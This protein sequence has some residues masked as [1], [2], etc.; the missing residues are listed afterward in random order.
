MGMYGIISCFMLECEEWMK[1][2]EYLDIAIKGSPDQKYHKE[3]LLGHSGSI[4]T[5]I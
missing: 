4:T 3:R 1:K 5:E 2:T